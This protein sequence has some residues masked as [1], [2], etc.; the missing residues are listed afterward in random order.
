MLSPYWWHITPYSVAHY[1]LYCGAL[2]I[3]YVGLGLIVGLLVVI[4]HNYLLYIGRRY[5]HL[6][7]H[8]ILHCLVHCVRRFLPRRGLIFISAIHLLDVDY[9]LIVYF[10]SFYA[11]SGIWLHNTMLVWIYL[12]MK[13]IISNKGISLC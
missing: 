13:V 5:S 4:V 2:H 6:Y 7:H 3:M 1:P 8:I 11:I 9:S 12:V 10:F